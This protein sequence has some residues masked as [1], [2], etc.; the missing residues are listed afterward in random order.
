MVILVVQII[1]YTKLTKQFFLGFVLTAQKL[2]VL[3]LLVR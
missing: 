1:L 3:H 2:A